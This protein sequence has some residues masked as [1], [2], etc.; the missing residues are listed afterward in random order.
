[1]L[2]LLLLSLLWAGSQAQYGRF[3]L[4]VESVTVQEGLCIRV[5]CN[6]SYPAYGYTDSDPAHGYWF[7]E[8]EYQ[9][10]RTLVATNNPDHEVQEATQGRF[11]LLGDPRV[12]DCSLDIRDAR[13]KDSGTYFFRIERGF[14]AKYDYRENPL[15][16]RVTAL[17]Q[18][19]DVHFQGTLESGHP[20]NITCAVPW[21]CERGTPPTFSWIGVA[22]NPWGPKSPHSSVLT[23]TPGPQDHGTNL[24]CQVTFPG[25]GVSSER[26]IQLNVSYAPQNLTISVF[27]KEGTAFLPGPEALG[28]GSSLPVQEG[29]SLRLVCVAH[30]NPPARMSWTRGSLPLNPSQPSNPGVLELP[31]VELRDHGKYVCRAQHLL[32]SLEASL[33]LFVTKPPQLFGPSC[34]WEDKGLQCSCSAQAQPA[35]SLYWRLREELVEGNHSNTSLTVTSSSTGPWANS[36]LILSGGLCSSLK[37][38]CE[39]R[40][41]H[42]NQ[43]T[44]VLL[45][46]G[47]PG[48]R[49][50]AIVGAIGG[51]GVT[52][53]L[54]LCFCLI[55]FV[56]KIYRKKWA[57]KAASRDGVHPAL[58]TVSWL[59]SGLTHHISCAR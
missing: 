22:L 39:A 52:A 35:P 44:T 27:R 31:Q 11:H 9:H 59:I 12:Y 37:L 38:S 10:Q 54:A 20:K 16:M 58:S 23:L 42:G 50:G 8:W 45:L 43:S 4:Q 28:N 13:R 17:T 33:S 2:P 3:Q 18:T 57:E 41:A 47:R 26:T 7:R 55:F 51:A 14:Y 6:V 32:G 40:N 24:T 48:P 21:A 19:P 25:A 49:T 36:S 53:L 34:S 30:S 1:M 5:P 15:S 46:P 56:V 29:Q